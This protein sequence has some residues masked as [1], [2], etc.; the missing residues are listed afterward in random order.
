M[1]FPDPADPLL[2]AY[3][4]GY[5]DATS[6]LLPALEAA[7]RQA[8]TDPLTG[9]PNR[10]ATD[11]RLAS[12]GRD[13]HL[14][15]GLVDVCR[16]KVVN[17]TCGH[18]T[19]DQLLRA[20]ASV[21]STV[22]E[23]WVWV[24]R[25]GGDEF[26]YATPE[27]DGEQPERIAARIHTALSGSGH[28][29]PDLAQPEVRIGWAHTSQ[30]PPGEALEAAGVALAAAQKTGRPRDGSTVLSVRYQTDVR[31]PAQRGPDTV[32]AVGHAVRGHR[33][34]VRSGR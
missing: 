15:L 10:R 4:S 25:H 23:P 18:S 2:L 26:L 14:W 31:I 34:W 1:T 13:A 17:D 9:L 19:G 30:T 6:R 5:Q 29:H 7:C 11:R 27:L 32:G 3:Q 20:V 21:L 12:A 24:A 22:A 33:G 28:D 8:L 16:L